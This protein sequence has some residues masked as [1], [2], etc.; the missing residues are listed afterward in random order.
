MTPVDDSSSVGK[1]RV[2]EHFWP[3]SW[4]ITHDFQVRDDCDAFDPQYTT[5]AASAKLVILSIS[6]RFRGL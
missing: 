5:L 3:L 4:V 2:F 6:G 1:T